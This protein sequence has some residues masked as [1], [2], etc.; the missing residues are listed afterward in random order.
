MLQQLLAT[1][2]QLKIHRE[3]R[4][5]PVYS[6]LPGR[7]GVKLRESKPDTPTKSLVI[8]TGRLE[9]DRPVEDRTEVLE[10]THVTRSLPVTCAVSS[11]ALLWT[12]PD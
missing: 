11:T 7:N 10:D 3:P 8:S 9:G 1:R 2:F 4:E 5:T 6:L 12:K